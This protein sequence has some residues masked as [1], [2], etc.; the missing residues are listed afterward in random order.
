MLAKACTTL[1]HPRGA[2]AVELI[3]AL[4][5]SALVVMGVVKLFGATI[6]QKF[7]DGDERI[8]G[9]DHEKE[10]GS[11]GSQI[12]AS[13]DEFEENNS[14]SAGGTRVA[15]KQKK[16]VGFGSDSDTNE[17]SEEQRAEQERLKKAQQK[18]YAVKQRKSDYERRFGS[19]QDDDRVKR[20]S[21]Q[22]AVRLPGDGPTVEASI[23]PFILLLLFLIAGGLVFFIFK[24][25]T[26]GNDS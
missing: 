17:L 16:S 5:L 6:E 3:I 12:V 18:G 1:R 9:M 21:E 4:I 15:I 19:S 26:V 24:G 22:R 14:G 25:Q 20:D 2:S 10:G 11:G 23:N 7:R 8:S 13:P